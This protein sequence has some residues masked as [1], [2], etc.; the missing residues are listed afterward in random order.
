M[1]FSKSIPPK[2]RERRNF[3]PFGKLIPINQMA[4]WTNSGKIVS[5]FSADFRDIDDETAYPLIS[6]FQPLFCLS[7]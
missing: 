5:S 4:F 3:A 2:S 1:I 6:W 7:N